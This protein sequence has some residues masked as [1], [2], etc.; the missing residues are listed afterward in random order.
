MRVEDAVWMPTNS[1]ASIHR[2]NHLFALARMRGPRGTMGEIY[3]GKYSGR[4]VTIRTILIA[5]VERKQFSVRSP[6]WSMLIS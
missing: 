4:F 6:P 2:T 5:N 1:I 3:V